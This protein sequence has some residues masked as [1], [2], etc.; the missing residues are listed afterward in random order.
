MQETTC[1]PL[2][3][4]ILKCHF[5][6]I[7]RSQSFK[8]RRQR[9]VFVLPPMLHLGQAH[10][11]ELDIPEVPANLGRISV[12][13][14]HHLRMGDQHTTPCWHL[15]CSLYSHLDTFQGSNMV[16]YQ[17]LRSRH[18]LCWQFNDE[19][20]CVCIQPQIQG[21][22]HSL[23]GTESLLWFIAILMLI[24]RDLHCS[25]PEQWK[26]DAYSSSHQPASR[27]VSTKSIFETLF[28]TNTEELTSFVL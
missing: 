28:L 17:K 7:L 12:C 14:Q 6:S 13:T 8:Y 10:Q 22:L 27:Q 4:Q 9:S 2:H 25:S 11:G 15:V 21:L 18:I 19:L 1:S 23:V 3:A 5:F 24:N 20:T 26:Q 16:V